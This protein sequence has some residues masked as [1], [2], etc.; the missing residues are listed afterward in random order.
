MA[1]WTSGASPGADSEPFVRAEQEANW[2]R[3]ERAAGRISEEQL[4]TRLQELMIQDGRGEWWAV[5]QHSGEWYRNQGGQWE[6]D[7]PSSLA[8]APLPTRPTPLYRAGGGQS[9]RVAALAL[10]VICLLVLPFTAYSCGRSLFASTWHS[11]PE[12]GNTYSILLFLL[13]GVVGTLIT[14]RVAG[15][16]W[17]EE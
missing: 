3:Q 12:L 11:N 2:L 15:K 7:V 14:L 1:D 9:R 17:R 8:T 13:A 16:W 5:G 10:S 4:R 6:R